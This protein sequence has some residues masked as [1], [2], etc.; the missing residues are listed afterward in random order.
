MTQL[1]WSRARSNSSPCS[2][3]WR[4]C[5]GALTSQSSRVSC[6]K[7]KSELVSSDVVPNRRVATSKKVEAVVRIQ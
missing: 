4:P 3:Y 2:K 6:G 7:L 5:K 1:T